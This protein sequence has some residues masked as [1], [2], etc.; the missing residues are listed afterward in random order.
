M[1]VVFQVFV[2]T[3]F[4]FFFPE[5]GHRMHTFSNLLIIPL[6]YFL[7]I[8]NSFGEGHKESVKKGEYGETITYSCMKMEK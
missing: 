1:C 4:F 8:K 5:Q 3:Y 2:D 6:T 7:V